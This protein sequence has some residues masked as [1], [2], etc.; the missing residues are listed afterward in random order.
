VYH[1]ISTL[2]PIIVMSGTKD[3]HYQQLASKLQTLSTELAHTH[4]M[5]GILGIHLRSMNNLG[6]ANAAQFMAVSR[7]LD[8][9]MVKTELQRLSDASAPH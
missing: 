2:I 7:I 5:F 3:R 1:C 9:E 6:A 4:E 8:A